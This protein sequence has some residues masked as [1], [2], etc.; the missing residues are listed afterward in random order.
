MGTRVI[1]VLADTR[2]ICLLAMLL[3][4]QWDLGFESRNPFGES[5]WGHGQSVSVP[6]AGVNFTFSVLLYLRACGSSWPHRG[7]VLIA[8]TDL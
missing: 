3:S 6:S 7:K 2:A 1:V 8:E 5:K 4:S